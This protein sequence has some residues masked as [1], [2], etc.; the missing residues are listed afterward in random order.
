MWTVATVNKLGNVKYL[1]H[2]RYDMIDRCVSKWD[3]AVIVMKVS[4]ISG[5][6][7]LL[8][9]FNLFLHANQECS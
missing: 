1:F 4:M 6:P 9:S 7:C 2:V 8:E 5:N 3:Q